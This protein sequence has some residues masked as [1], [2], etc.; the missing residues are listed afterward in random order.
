MINLFILLGAFSSAAL[1]FLLLHSYIL[2][3]RSEGRMQL[4][5]NA[6]PLGA[7]F[8]NK[9]GKVI[10][11][12]QNALDMFG[13]TNK[14]EFIERF[15]E[16]SPDYQPDGSLSKN[17]FI[18]N[19]KTAMAD[20]YHRFEW[21]HHKF[22]GELVPCEVTLIRDKYKNEYIILSYVR[23]LREMKIMM[24]EIERH[25]RLLDIVNSAAAIL[26][27]GND[28]ADFSN[29][30]L[31]S[32][33]LV[34]HCLDVDR[35]QLWRNESI[36]EEIHFVLR[37]EWLSD[38]GKNRMKVPHGL[39]FP[40]SLKKDWEKRFLSGSYINS[41]VSRLSEED[42]EFL[43]YYEIK[44]IVI[45]P[46]F[47]D[48]IFWGFFSL[49]DC[50]AERTFSLKEIN[51]LS[52]AGL[53][54]TTAVN[55]NI[56]NLKIR[57]ADDKAEIAKESSKAKSDFLA[58][59]SHEIR[60]PMNA[61]LGITEIQLQDDTLPQITKE[62]FERIYNSGDLLLGIINDIL[63]LSKIEA[64]ML[65]LNVGQYDVASLIN[66]TVQLNIMRFE[67]KPIDFKLN[68]DK[69]IPLKLIGDE[70]RIKQILNNLLSNAYKYTEEGFVT[71]SISGIPDNKN[72]IKIVFRISDSGQGMTP[73]QINRL[74]NEY[75]RFNLEANRKTEGTGL[76]MNITRNMIRFMNGSIAIEST[77]GKGSVFTVTL[78]QDI[79]DERIIG[80][81]LADNLMKLNIGNNLKVRTIQIKRE[82]MPYGRILIVDDVET[83]L[84]V[85]K[86]LL[87][88]YGLSI[89]T[90]MSGF[91]A[92]EKIKNGCDFDIIFMDHMMPK[93][94]GIETTRI[95]RSLNYDKPIVA[96]T[97]N[98]LAGQAEM[99]LKCGFDDFI[100]KPID[101]RQLNVALNKL[102]RDKMPPEVIK[103][104]REQKEQLFNRLKKPTVD[105]Q[106]AEYFI[107]DAEKT[108]KALEAL[109]NNEC[110]SEDDIS[111]FIINVH[112]MKSA[113]ANIGETNLSETASK[114][115]Q[116]GR[117][118]NVKR[119][120]SDIPAFLDM[121]SVVTQKLE[122][123]CRTDETK[124]I[125]GNTVLLREKL[126]A[127]KAEC[128]NYNKKAAK[129]LLAEL[130]Q[131]SWPGETDGL[132]GKLA[133]LL[134][135]SEFDEAVKV[136][137]E[138]IL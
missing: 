117:D 53:M 90:A 127:I 112:S 39:H 138:R 1:I 55:R 17:V 110:K 132:L 120:L 9:N 73:E 54:M 93:M 104:A 133:E 14:N 74:G 8:W 122:S 56:Q 108:A 15:F 27:S 60:T 123:Q 99:F 126:N 25:T 7:A 41:P 26:L 24:K 33:D 30:L 11:C 16:L 107:H 137:E 5:F 44:S 21:L 12:N 94:D 43:G 91:D 130:R 34:G 72:S 51:I 80:K 131:K 62:A 63:D 35:V 100:S 82:F 57:E 38:F 48:G 83:N 101:I 3:I 46:M 113:L 114:L 23:D 50:R 118:R 129:D 102:I 69:N 29:V 84:Y 2:N 18:E 31:K 52:S 95:I 81:E 47:L 106:L 119:I 65:S 89:D 58:R 66:D 77:P 19:F 87:A 68:V 111:Q 67:S 71:L 49:D 135:H 70:L 105:K 20:G 61:I 97:A 134:L 32:F 78:P 92:I 76:G 6:T 124:N 28:T 121:L 40:Y 36:G 115:E 45:I 88:P 86:G 96:L 42:K 4:M 85:A 98:A 136:I 10:D 22:N 103:A 64:G 13:I 79:S 109:Y 37:Y 75:S 116:A 59:M 128:L 125:N